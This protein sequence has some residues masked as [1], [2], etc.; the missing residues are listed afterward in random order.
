MECSYGWKRT[1]G[2]DSMQIENL[3]I[4][5]DVDF[6]DTMKTKDTFFNMNC[7]KVRKKWRKRNFGLINFLGK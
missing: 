3:M 5:R 1:D 4:I 6:E 2:I 7:T